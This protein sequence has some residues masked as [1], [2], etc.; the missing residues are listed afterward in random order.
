MDSSN[1][2]KNISITVKKTTVLPDCIDDRVK[3]WH[4]TLDRYRDS[5]LIEST[6]Y[7]ASYEEQEDALRLTPKRQEHSEIKV[8]EQDCIYAA[9]EERGTF[10]TCILNMA[11][12]DIA[13]GCVEGG[14]SA[15]EEELFRRSNLHKHLHQKYYPLKAWKRDHVTGIVI[16]PDIRMMKTIYSRDVEFFRDGIDKGYKLMDNSIYFDVIS[17]PA[18]RWRDTTEDGQYFV[19]P[20]DVQLMKDKIRN[21]FILAA[22]EGVETLILSAWGCGA[23]GGPPRHTAEIFKEVLEEADGLIPKVVFAITGYNYEI[24]ADILKPFTEA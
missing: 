19:S 12:W 23:F 1:Q 3:I 14:S 15:Q 2:V 18:L 6:V 4:D 17:S 22:H 16:N 10:R 11:D 5:P 13:G 20:L 9:L 7:V 24:F 21:L 8:L